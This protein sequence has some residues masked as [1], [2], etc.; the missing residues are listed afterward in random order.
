MSATEKLMRLDPTKSVVPFGDGTNHQFHHSD[1]DHLNQPSG[2]S[3]EEGELLYGLVRILKPLRCLETGTNIGV[4]ASYT[5]L[6]LRDNGVGTLTTIE[7][8]PYVADIA[9]RKLQGMGFTNFDVIACKVAELVTEDVFDFLWLDTELDQRFAELVRFYPQ[10]RVGAIACIHDL[11]RLHTL[12]FG[13]VPKE[14]DYLITSRRL[15]MLNFPTPHGVTVLQK[16][17]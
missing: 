8:S 3:I 7:H 11:P 4:S 9:R 16:R 2:I 14:L 12:E 6:A 1:F 15:A 10:M 5:C 17:E 13:D